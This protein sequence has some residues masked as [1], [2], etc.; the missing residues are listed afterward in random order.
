MLLADNASTRLYF[1]PNADYNGTSTGALTLR[2]WDQTSG[3]AG[4][5]VTTASNGGTTAFS[6]ATDTID[7]TVSAVNDALTSD[8]ADETV[9]KAS[10]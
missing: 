6:S 5:K 7:V 10:L 3:T 2:A 8:E 9:Q 1:A 4:T